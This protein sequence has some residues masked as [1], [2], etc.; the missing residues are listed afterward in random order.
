MRVQAIRKAVASG[1]FRRALALWTAHVQHLQESIGRGEVHPARLAELRDLVN[2]AV[3]VAMCSR[4]HLQNELASLS[5]ASQIQP[6]ESEARAS[7]R[8]SL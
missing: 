8:R 7:V 5:V 2:W 4:A 6:P 3:E 1:E